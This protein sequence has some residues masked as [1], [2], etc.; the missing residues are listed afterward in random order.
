MGYLKIITEDEYLK[1]QFKYPTI[2]YI[3]DANIVRFAAPDGYTTLEFEDGIFQCS[4]G[5]FLLKE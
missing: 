3:K 2:C 4:D 1:N 5:D